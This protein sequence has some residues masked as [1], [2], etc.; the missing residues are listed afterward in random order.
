[1]CDA[2]VPFAESDFVLAIGRQAAVALRIS[3]AF[4]VPVAVASQSQSHTRARADGHA[5]ARF[6]IAGPVV[7]CDGNG[8]FLSE[9][10]PY[11]EFR[12]VD[13]LTGTPL[14]L[15]GGTCA[16]TD[17]SGALLWRA[18]NML[19]VRGDASG[20]SGGVPLAERWMTMCDGFRF[21][22]CVVRAPNHELCVLRFHAGDDEDAQWSAA[23]LR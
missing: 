15:D 2:V 23:P 16:V 11:T 6:R 1:M 14:P 12:I 22:V 3:G 13:A 20:P 7:L 5:S 21:G 10:D 17:T 19:V 18:G 8:R 4:P 9:W